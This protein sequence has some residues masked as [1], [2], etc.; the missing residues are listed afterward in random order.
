MF[1]I[2]LDG[3]G[4]LREVNVCFFHISD[5]QDVAAKWQCGATST[6]WTVRL[7]SLICILDVQTCAFGSN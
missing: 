6:A 7:E 4:K 2:V 1:L 5:L 3:F